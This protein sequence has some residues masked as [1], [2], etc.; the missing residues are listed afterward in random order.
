MDAGLLV[1]LAGTNFL[2]RCSLEVKW[3][4]HPTLRTQQKCRNLMTE[5]DQMTQFYKL[6]PFT[7]WSPDSNV[8]FVLEVTRSPE[9][10][11]SHQTC[12][13]KRLMPTFTESRPGQHTGDIKIYSQLAGKYSG[14][15][16]VQLWD[17][18]V[19]TLELFHI[20]LRKHFYGIL[21]WH[22]GFFQVF[23][24]VFDRED[25]KR[26]LNCIDLDSNRPVV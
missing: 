25:Q 23:Q 9:H 24:A 19:H 16:Y 5:R 20:F 8:L 10:S 7:V 17:S 6:Q 12:S 15:E 14:G 3:T 2:T 1:Q 22:L 11:Y 4:R 26:T 13:G 18:T 21:I